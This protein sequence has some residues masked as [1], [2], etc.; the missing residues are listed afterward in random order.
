VEYAEQGGVKLIDIPIGKAL[1]AVEMKSGTHCCND[2]IF[3][4][5]GCFMLFYCQKVNRADG[6]N[7]VFKLVDMPE[8]AG[9]EKSN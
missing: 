2:C 3:C 4:S 7:V 9:N 1:I 5:A 8:E 6:K